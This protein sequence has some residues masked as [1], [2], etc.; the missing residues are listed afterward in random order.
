MTAKPPPT[1]ADDL[2]R[3]AK[4]IGN[5]LGKTEREIY[6]LNRTGATRSIFTK[7]NQLHAR[8]S[9]LNTEFSANTGP[10]AA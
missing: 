10:E 8:K 9:E 6:H 7:G 5:Y 3:G 4:E 2:L 1:L